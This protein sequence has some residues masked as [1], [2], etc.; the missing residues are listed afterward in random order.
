[1]TDNNETLITWGETVKALDDKG[2]IG[3]YLVRF[4]DAKSPDLEGDFFN[5]ETDF[6]EPSTLPLMY[7]HGFDEILGT[8]RIG[9]GTAEAQDAGLWMEA[10]LNLA[11]DY[12]QKVFELV[13]PK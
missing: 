9:R 7:D 2:K 6:G 4:T 11:N 13:L 5:A 8:K 3:G 10:Q 1:M 12:Q